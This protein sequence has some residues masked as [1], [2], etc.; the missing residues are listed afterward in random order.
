MTGHLREPGWKDSNGEREHSGAH[1]DNLEYPYPAPVTLA[2]SPEG[3]GKPASSRRVKV[4]DFY[5][6]IIRAIV[7]FRMIHGPPPA[8][9]FQ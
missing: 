3:R 5:T 8:S 2:V 7:M 1:K 9:P 6:G 4:G